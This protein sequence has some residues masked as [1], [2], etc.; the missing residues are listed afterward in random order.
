MRYWDG[1][2]WTAWVADNSW[3]P[4]MFSDTGLTQLTDFGT[5]VKGWLAAKA[6]SDWVQ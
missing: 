4:N 2:K 6:S 1:A 5:L 3:S